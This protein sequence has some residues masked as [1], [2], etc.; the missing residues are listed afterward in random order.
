[1]NNSLLVKSD[2]NVEL[3]LLGW[4]A[5]NN[6]ILQVP[7]DAFASVDTRGLYLAHLDH[8]RTHQ[9][10]L[11]HEHVPDDH[12]AVY[13]E[14]LEHFAGRDPDYYVGV[15]LEMYRARRWASLATRAVANAEA[16]DDTDGYLKEVTDKM[17][18]VLFYGKTAGRYNHQDVIAEHIAYL[19]ESKRNK[20]GLRGLDSCLPG[21]DDILNGWQRGKTYILAGLEKLGKTRLAVTIVGNWSRARIP[22]ILYEMEESAQG[23]HEIIYAGRLGINSEVFGTSRISEAELIQVSEEGG[24]LA[25]EPLYIDTTSSV[26]V[27]QVEDGIRRL[28]DEGTPVTWVLVDY[29]QRMVSGTDRVGQLEDTSKGLADIARKHEVI[30]IVLSQVSAEYEKQKGMKKSKRLPVYVFVKGSKGIRE[31]A[32]AVITLDDPNRG[33][34]WTDEDTE[35]ELHAYVLQRGGRSDVYV[36][37]HADLARCRFRTPSVRNGKTGDTPAPAMPYYNQ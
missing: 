20:R 23:I 30:M 11:Q 32:D 21:L 4:M 14:S 31:A 36:R 2:R 19:Y 24:R 22:G 37:I 8:N 17:V 26:P 27:R 6:K 9:S 18:K 34:V 12:L 15:L 29:L 7:A 33:E 1:M 35:K 25:L 5:V 28:R 3:A 10:I 13:S 16:V